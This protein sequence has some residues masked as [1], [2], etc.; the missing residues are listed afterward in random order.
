MLIF[1]PKGN[2]ETEEEDQDLFDLFDQLEDEEVPDDV[3]KR[4]EDKVKEE[5]KKQ[6]DEKGK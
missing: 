3:Q 6:E 1:G 4:I 2:G 5:L